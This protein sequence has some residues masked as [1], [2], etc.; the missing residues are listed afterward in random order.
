MYMREIKP[1]TFLFFRTE[2][3]VSEL[4][5][6]LP[7]GQR[8][9]KEAVS[10]EIDITGPIHWHYSQFQG[11]LSKPFTLEI[12]LPVGHAPSEY[13]GQFHFKRSQNFRAV[14]ATHHGSWLSIPETYGK[15]NNFMVENS[16]QGLGVNREI[17]VN[18]DMRF[19]EANTTEIQ[20]GIQ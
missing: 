18:V 8:L 10:S 12:S 13:D 17:Y 19:P 1:I 3:T 5:K 15:I 14:V 2:T 9:F 20:I 7:V 16:L 4:V 6:Y 11:D